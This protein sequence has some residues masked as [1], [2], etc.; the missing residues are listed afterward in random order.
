[1]TNNYYHKNIRT[2]F[3]RTF[4]SRATFFSLT[5]NSKYSEYC[6]SM[7]LN[8]SS[9]YDSMFPITTYSTTALRTVP[10]L[11]TIT[12]LI[13]YCVRLLHMILPQCYYAYCCVLLLLR[14]TSTYTG[15]IIQYYCTVILIQYMIDFWAHTAC[16]RILNI[17]LKVWYSIQV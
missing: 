15:T 13:C 4:W 17:L 1:M 6:I 5:S 8:E 7:K 10:L 2:F 9:M 12:C 16:R 3:V 14:T 11:R